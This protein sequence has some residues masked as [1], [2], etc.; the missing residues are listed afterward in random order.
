M[1]KIY[2]EFLDQLAEWKVLYKDNPKEEMIQL[3]LL[4]LEREQIVTLAF[5]AELVAKRLNELSIP[6]EFKEL[7]NHALLWAWKDEEMHT[8]YIRG[9]C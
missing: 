3:C 5:D 4:A 9:Y 7:I 6:A 8:I 2:D 1:G